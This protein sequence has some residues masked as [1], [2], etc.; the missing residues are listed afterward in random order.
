[1]MTWKITLTYK[2]SGSPVWP[3]VKPIATNVYMWFHFRIKE[4]GQESTSPF[5]PIEKL[6][7]HVLC[8]LQEAT[9]KGAAHIRDPVGGSNADLFVLVVYNS[10]HMWKKSFTWLFIFTVCI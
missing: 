6:K 9:V 8:A 1:M 3:V 2:S 4:A 5:F 7:E 10:K